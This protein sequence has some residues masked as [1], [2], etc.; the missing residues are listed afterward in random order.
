MKYL[1]TICAGLLLAFASMTVISA[2]PSRADAIFYRGYGAYR[3]PYYWR[4]GYVNPYRAY[5]PYRF[6]YGGYGGYYG[7]SPYYSWYRGY[8]WG[9]YW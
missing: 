2:T 7:V 4:H 5:S 3:Y 6:G 1:R 9:G 8:P